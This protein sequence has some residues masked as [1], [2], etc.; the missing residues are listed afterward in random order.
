M[1][2]DLVDTQAVEFLRAWIARDLAPDPG[3]GPIPR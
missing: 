3:P 1:G 2:S